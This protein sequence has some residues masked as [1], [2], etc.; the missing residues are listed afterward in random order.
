MIKEL[1]YWQKI[2]TNKQNM[3]FYD[4]KKSKFRQQKLFNENPQKRK[5]ERN[6][7]WKK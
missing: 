5:L 2:Q 1:K 4:T 7:S 3:N 6:I